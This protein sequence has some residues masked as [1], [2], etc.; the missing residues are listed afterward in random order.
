MASG[1]AN[2]TKRPNTWLHRP[3]CGREESP[4]QP[5]AV[6]TWHIASN[7]QCAQ[8]VRNVEISRLTADAKSGGRSGIR[9]RSTDSPSPMHTAMSKVSVGSA[10]DKSGRLL[11]M[12]LLSRSCR[13]NLG[14]A[15]NH[16][17]TFCRI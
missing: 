1:H 13:P 4:C 14:G 3:A 12:R 5:G 6:H 10:P 9:N 8:D 7:E 15:R 11:Q 2:R 17:N 16:S